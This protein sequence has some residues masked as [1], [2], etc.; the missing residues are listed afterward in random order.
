[1]GSGILIPNSSA[2]KDSQIPD[3]VKNLAGWW[4]SDE[5]SENEFLAGIAYLINKNI[6]S[7]D[8]IPCS[9]KIL[10]PG[11]PEPGQPVSSAE[12]VPD[13]VKNNAK[14]WSEDQIDDNTFANGIEFLIK[15]GIIVV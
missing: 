14:W 13:W 12:L 15:V 7:L 2:Q 5:I 11:T 9:T 8:F 6:I 3:W 10:L 1:M 4:A